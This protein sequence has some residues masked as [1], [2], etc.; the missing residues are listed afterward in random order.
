MPCLTCLPSSQ[1]KEVRPPLRA[2]DLVEPCHD[3]TNTDTNTLGITRLDL[4]GNEQ[5]G[6]EKESPVQTGQTLEMVR[7]TG[8]ELL[9]QPWNVNHLQARTH[10]ETH[11][12]L[13]TR[14]WRAW[15]RC[16]H[17]CP[18]NRRRSFVR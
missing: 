14:F 12:I 1:K 6:H 7:G 18:K 5:L 17:L 4:S 16:G 8:F 11:K 2:P 10:K 13:S 15:S 3:L 9:I